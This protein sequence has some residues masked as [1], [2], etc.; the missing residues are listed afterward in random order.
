ML[1]ARDMYKISFQLCKVLN[2]S[3]IPFGNLNMVFSGDFAQYH[4]HWV[5]K[6]FHYI[7][8]LLVQYHQVQNL[9]RKLLERLFGIRLQQL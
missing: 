7:A 4:L 9:K 3:E 1:S 5:V 8:K 6:M 2:I